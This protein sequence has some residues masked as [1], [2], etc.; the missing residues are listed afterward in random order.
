MY[1]LAMHSIPGRPKFT[2]IRAREG[3]FQTEKGPDEIYHQVPF[4]ISDFNP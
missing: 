3:I 1:P 2:S 4:Y